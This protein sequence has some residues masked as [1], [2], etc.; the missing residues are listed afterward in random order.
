MLINFTKMRQILIL[1]SIACFLSLTV[2]A[3]HHAVLV[4]GSN[5]FYNYRHQADVFHAYQILIS[6]GVPKENIITMAYD[7]IAKDRYNPFPGQVFNQPS[8]GP[9]RDVYEGV[10]LD[11]RRADVTPQKFLNVLLGD[12]AANNGSKVLDTTEE[13]NIFIYFADHGAPGLLAFPDEYLYADDFIS[14]LLT[15][16]ENKRYKNMVIYIEACESGSMFERLLPSDINIYAV[17]ASNSE[18]NSWAAYC[19]PND[20]VNG[21]EIGSCLGDL[22]SVNFLENIESIDPSTEVIS[23]QYEIVYGQTNLSHVQ[24]YG[25]FTLGLV[26]I[27]EFLGDGSSYEPLF[28]Q[29]EMTFSRYTKLNSIEQSPDFGRYTNIDSRMIKLDFLKRRHER[30]G[31]NDTHHELLQEVD[32]INTLDSIF[33]SMEDQLN[34][35]VDRG[36]SEID[37]DCLKQRMSM[38]EEL[39]GKLSDYGLKYVNHIYHSCRQKVDIDSYR[40]ILMD[41]CL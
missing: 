41:Y 34:L 18:E 19:A 17:T 25:D 27:A 31:N 6:Y 11:Y 1:V 5:G 22:F 14:T 21:I 40:A 13:D 33:N 38:Y 36:V 29:T 26:V 28:I 12:S 30:H 4:A 9:G 10:V 3:A 20:I 37:F 7:D 23:I 16:H 15:M 2:K 35:D 24:R 39:C 32:E 8:S